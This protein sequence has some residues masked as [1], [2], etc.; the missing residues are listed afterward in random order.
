M[1]I[2]KRNKTWE[3]DF[4]LGGRGGKRVRKAFGNK[5]DAQAYERK[6]KLAE[7]NGDTCEKKKENISLCVLIEKYKMLHD[8]GNGDLTQMRNASILRILVNVLSD[9]PLR[10]I[11]Q[12]EIETYKAKRLKMVKPVT[13]NIELRVIRSLFNRGCEWGYLTKSPAT[14]VKLIR[15]DERPPHFLTQEQGATVIETAK[16]QMKTFI[17]MGLYTGLRRMEMFRLKW[18]DIDTAKLELIVRKSKG[19]K[20]RIVPINQNLAQILSKHPR[21]ISG[22]LVFYGRNGNQWQDPRRGFNK[23][24]LDAGLPTMRIHDM[25]HSFI[26]NLVASGVDLRTVKEL[27]GHSNIQ[28][29]MKYAHLAKGQ[30]HKAIEALNW[31]QNEEVAMIGDPL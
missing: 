2:R 15:I 20:F 3:V 12:E 11:T 19:K 14:R 17:A 6:Y 8:S 27:A 28:T 21:Y 16:G 5:A 4:Y 24:F 25:R 13:V 22:E 23:V 1:S 30:T 7:Y 31:S 10:G 18:S 29:T 26:S 9:L